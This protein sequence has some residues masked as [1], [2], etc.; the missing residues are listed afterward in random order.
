LETNAMSD[1]P[2][3][4]SGEP[5]GLE[6]WQ[7][8]LYEYIRSVTPAGI[9]IGN[10]P[11]SVQ[12]QLASL[13]APPPR[14]Q[15]AL[16]ALAMMLVVTQQI[17]G[18]SSG[19]IAQAMVHRVLAA[20]ITERMF[21]APPRLLDEHDPGAG[22]VMSLQP[23]STEPFLMAKLLA[24]WQELGFPEDLPAETEVP[25]QTGTSLTLPDLGFFVQST[26][27]AN[28]RFQLAWND[29]SRVQ[30]N[31]GTRWESGRWALLDGERVV[32]S[33]HLARPNSGAVSDVGSA[34]IAD[35][36]SDEELQGDLIFVDTDGQVSRLR[37]YAA[38]LYGVGMSQSGRFAA[39]STLAAPSD[40]ASLVAVW[41]MRDRT[42]LWRRHI[43]RVFGEVFAFDESR[44]LLWLNPATANQLAFHLDGRIATDIAEYQTWLVTA[45]ASSAVV[46]VVT[47]QL[48]EWGIP[49]GAQGE[50]V[51]QWLSGA[52]QRSTQPFEQASLLRRMGEVAE[53]LGR[54]D[55]VIEYWRRAVALNPNVGVKQKLKKIDSGFASSPTAKGQLVAQLDGRIA[56]IGEWKLDATPS[57]IQ[58]GGGDTFI[59]GLGQS[60]K[61]NVLFGDVASGR[62]IWR[63]SLP[64]RIAYV[65]PYGEDAWL[66]I[67][68]QGAV[69]D[70][71]TGVWRISAAG[72][73]QMLATLDAVTTGPPAVGAAGTGVGC[74]NGCLYCLGDEGGMVWTHVVGAPARASSRKLFGIRIGFGSTAEGSDAQAQGGDSEGGG[75]VPSP[76]HVVPDVGDLCFVYA[77][78]AG[79]IGVGSDGDTRWQLGEPGFL[80]MGTG[81]L[82]VDAISVGPDGAVLIQR[83]NF[84]LTMRRADGS[85]KP[86]NPD[87]TSQRQLKAVD[88]QRCR[89]WAKDH[90]GL[91]ICD[92][93]G[94]TICERADGDNGWMWPGT[95]CRDGERLAI[96]HDS[97]VDFWDGALA[98]V[99][100][101]RF[102]GEQVRTVTAA[103][104]KYLVA[105]SKRVVLLDE[106]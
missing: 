60:A 74:R 80:D 86:L 100:S 44:S 94:R 90:D 46:T 16:E 67:A 40:D 11:S 26:T 62:A 4:W 99:A 12:S 76:Y 56:V 34:V 59:A 95:L 93:A 39:V 104:D 31:A 79:V 21:T 37:R 1:E 50:Q 103:G 24:R 45:A 92:F 28:G 73:P 84:R 83:R 41:D 72:D 30:T 102:A 9:A 85:T 47:L 101:A 82:L 19:V 7:R 70:G 5:E 75:P 89:L 38:N 98:H 3:R 36:T 97:T 55:K 66:A 29:G 27:S 22:H 2:I 15:A 51:L 96:W 49:D 43:D 65:V 69:A 35:W 6:G 81:S 88:W 8:D 33:G 61:G 48:A 78:G 91:I 13:D 23:A 52:V 18:R 10:L 64:G 58:H 54:T 57:V 105:T 68:T 87:A 17:A 14:N 71:T 106:R 32:H 77:C 53:A 25:V 42:E 63:L 20:F